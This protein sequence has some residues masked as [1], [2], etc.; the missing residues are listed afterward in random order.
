MITRHFLCLVLLILV[1][2]I[3]NIHAQESDATSFFTLGAGVGLMQVPQESD[4]KGEGISGNLFIDLDITPESL[5]FRIGAS[6]AKAKLEY[7][8]SS[9]TWTHELLTNAIY[10]AYRQEYFFS[11]SIKLFYLIGAAYVDALL[12]TSEDLE[13]SRTGGVG[14][15]FGLGGAIRFSSLALGIQ[16]Q[17][18]A[19][20]G[21]FSDYRFATGSNQIQLI[22]LYGF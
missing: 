3:P 21:E 15:I 4:F 1:L 14:S 8:A 13:D 12:K 20:T 7:E 9:I 5:N 19:H 2:L 10:L 22:V 16:A 11:D 18:I 6:T 17:T